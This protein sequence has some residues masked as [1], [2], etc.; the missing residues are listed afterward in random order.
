MLEIRESSTRRMNVA[1]ISGITRSC[2]VHS[3]EPEFAGIV[4]TLRTF[5]QSS[6]ATD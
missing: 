2:T 4:G 3:L 6:D 1:S 5:L